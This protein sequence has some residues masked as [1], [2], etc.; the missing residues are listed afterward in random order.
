MV[1]LDGLRVLQVLGTT[2]ASDD[3]DAALHL[4]RG[5][6]AIGAEVRTVALAP[7]RTVGVGDQVPTMAP[8]VGSLA[9]HTQLRR[10]QRWADVV[11]LRGGAPAAA[12]GLLGGRGAPPTV[13]QLGA[14]A[15]RWCGTPVPS[16]VRR[17]ARRGAGLVVTHD[18]DR[19]VGPLL[20]MAQSDVSVIPFGVPGAPT[21]SGVH[22]ERARRRSAARVEMGISSDV[23]VAL[24]LGDGAGTDAALH[25]AAELGVVTLT[26]PGARIGHRR[27]HGRVERRV[28]Y[29]EPGTP[30]RARGDDDPGATDELHVAAADLVVAPGAPVFGPP[31]RLLRAAAQGL[32]VVADREGVLGL[33]V[34]EGTGWSGIG[35]AVHAGAVEIHRRG[36]AAATRID[37]R[38]SL[39][40]VSQQWAALLGRVAGTTV[41]PTT[42]TGGP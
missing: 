39:G 5:L 25:E 33:L 14:E 41:A 13:L 29:G 42:P 24:V 22:V 23:V 28:R 40:V 21:G 19:Q 4:H 20:G 37:E 15:G 1:R 32:A 34:D 3:A 2:D 27:E 18:G 8:S 10:E 38:F 11:I 7:G 35:P 16:R 26:D 31:P 6:S 36:A 17:L 9:A 30:Q 12:A